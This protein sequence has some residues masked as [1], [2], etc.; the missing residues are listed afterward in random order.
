MLDL[1]QEL[2]DLTRELQE[3]TAEKAWQDVEVIQAKRAEILKK[4]DQ[5]LSETSSDETAVEV[6]QLL[7]SCKKLE[8]EC[9]ANVEHARNALTEEQQKLSRGKAM[10]KAYGKR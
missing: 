3:K 2:W 4:I 6:R 9:L 8:A 1:A 5:A 7:E 10:Q